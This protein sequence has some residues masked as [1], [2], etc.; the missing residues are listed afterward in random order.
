MAKEGREY[1]IFCPIDDAYKRMNYQPNARFSE[2]EILLNHIVA[3]DENEKGSLMLNTQ[4]ED[5]KVRLSL[6]NLN[7]DK[8]RNMFY[9]SNNKLTF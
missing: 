1:T 9:F 3:K 4:A 6:K 8:V 5:S 2:R 7:K